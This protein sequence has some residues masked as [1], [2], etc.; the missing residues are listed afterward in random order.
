MSPNEFQLRSALRD[1]EGDYVNPDTVIA[2]AR[3]MTRAR[4]DRRVRYASVAAAVAV[5]GGIGVAAGVALHTNGNTTAS[6][7]DRA[8]SADGAKQP[9]AAGPLRDAQTLACPATVP[10][11][12]SAGGSALDAGGSLFSGPLAAA[13]I[14]AYRQDGGAPIPGADGQAESTVLSGQQATALAASL[15]TASKVR[16]VDACPMYRTAQGKTLVIIGLSTT[17]RAM[18]PITVTVAQNPC[19]LPVTNGIAIRYNW[20]P[21]ASLHA[22]IL[23]LGQGDATDATHLAPSGKVIGSPIRS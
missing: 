19:D 16:P 20:S 4:H 14:C 12:N 10:Q 11:L 7:A 17:G 1:G 8:R 22:F 2:R 15:D 5:V 18:K 13:K 6:R 21:P 23:R 3:A 9:V